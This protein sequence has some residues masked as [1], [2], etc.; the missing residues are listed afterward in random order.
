MAFH[1]TLYSIPPTVSFVD[2]LAFGVMEDAK[3]KSLSL[4]DYTILLPNRRAQRTLREAFLRLAGHQPM[5]L[6]AMRPIGDVDEEEVSF[7]G[8]GL[9]SFDQSFIKPA[10]SSTRRLMIL[11]KVLVE[12]EFFP[13]KTSA[14]QAWRLARDLAKLMDQ[15][16][17]EGLNYSDLAKL[18]PEGLAHHWEITLEFLQII[19]NAWPNI[20]D[21]QGMVNPVVRRDAL[22]RTLCALWQKKP[23]SGQIIAAGSTG[24][25]P[26]TAELLK[27]I[28]RLENGAVVL[29][30]FDS[31]M[32]DY[33]WESVDTTHPQ[34]AMKNLIE[35]IGVS[36]HEIADWPLP[37][38][39]VDS[40]QARF[41]LINDALRPAKNTDIWPN[42]PYRTMPSDELFMGIHKMVA[43][44][45][46]EE[47]EAI[48]VMMREVLETPGKTAALVTPDRY[49]A[50][51]VRVALKRWDI[52]IDDSGGDRALI[53]QSGRLLSLI[54]HAAAAEFKPI[55]F[56]SLLQHPMVSA[57]FERTKFLAF[58]RRLDLSVM[59]GSRPEL[60]IDGIMRRAEKCAADSLVQFDEN[61]LSYLSKLR[62]ILAPFGPEYI[63][64]ASLTDVV[65]CHLAV[66]ERLT[67]VVEE[68]E[69]VN[70]A[71]VLWKGEAANAIADRLRDLIADS[72]DIQFATKAALSLEEYAALFDEMLN[73]VMVR[74]QWQKHPRLSIWGPLEARLQ[75]TDL[76]ILGGLNE[77][78]WPTDIKPDPW[79]S[80]PMRSEFGLP[81]LERRI[82]QSAHDFVQAVCAPNVVI[83]R[84]G[85]ID[86]AP[87][88]PSRWLFRIEALA[89]REIPHKNHYL[90]WASSLQNTET[91]TPALPPAPMPPLTARP[92]K[93]SVTQIETWMRDPYALY[94][95]KILR[96]KQLDD[97][98]ER[99]NAAQKGTLIHKVFERFMKLGDRRSG[100]A[101]YNQLIEIGRQVFDEII[102]Q[103]TVYAFWWPRFKDTARWFVEHEA[104][105]QKD[106]KTVLL[107]D[108]AELFFD[109]FGFTL[110]A[111]ADRIDQ[112]RTTGELA[113]IDYKTGN[114]PTEK[115]MRAGFAPQLPLEGILAQAGAFKE[116]DAAIVER[117]MFWLIKGGE[118]PGELQEK[119]K[120]TDISDIISDTEQ[121]LKTLLRA[122][123]EETTPYLSNPRPKQAG[124]GDYD[125][126]ARVKEWQ[127]MDTSGGSDGQ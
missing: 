116:L 75:N 9:G 106:Y 30:G 88:V 36:R 83:T 122:F 7:L 34:N 8:A 3:S 115:R 62:D 76:M 102:T 105:W 89:G 90:Y 123:G 23:P 78:I 60:G 93:L 126:L 86:G 112:N 49:L 59:R 110:T 121:G 97:V 118:K 47:A 20:L 67:G 39:V 117:M 14:A 91:S 124:Y 113:I 26:A 71:K 68:G 119:I 95:N 114:I 96:L 10:I 35:D 43:P 58:V 65:E 44:S 41:D 85:K 107:E 111:T 25:I 66:A 4:T 54:V 109:E 21:A 100:E 18:V 5:L 69:L 125:H 55:S 80:R 40:Q 37:G 77:G 92:K 101:G 63:N 104:A 1:P 2:A 45:R 56:L 15:V 82:G 73:D 64:S 28:S 22:I 24:S 52:D 31:S 53:S 72:K 29:P 6:P 38:M 13:S 19:S 48:A 120:S 98:D 33:A 79:M 16:E 84:A 99:P 108:K 94:A 127:A 11:T 17:T 27:L 32:D 74:P 46:R 81:A 87:T 70:G 12:R 103:P 57:G 50:R 61:D 51:Y 42:L